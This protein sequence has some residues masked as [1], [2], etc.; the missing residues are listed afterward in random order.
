MPEQNDMNGPRPLASAADISVESHLE[1]YKDWVT[2]SQGKKMPTAN[3]IDLLDYS[4]DALYWIILDVFQAEKDYKF[5]F[6]GPD[7]VKLFGVEPTGL[8]LNKASAEASYPIFVKNSRKILDMVV[9]TRAPV[10]KGP[11]TTVFQSGSFVSVTSIS[12]PMGSDDGPVKQI[13]CALQIV[14]SDKSI[15]M[16][17]NWRKAT[18]TI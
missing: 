15:A 6:V 8:S 10:V 13:V 7:L 2:K 16:D 17:T 18:H 1:L 3:S 4:G 14:F 5:R 9:E 11:T 12:L